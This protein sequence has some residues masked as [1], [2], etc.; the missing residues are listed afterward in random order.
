MI[1]IGWEA[2]CPR[3]NLDTVARTKIFSVRLE[4]NVDSPD[5]QSIMLV[6]LFT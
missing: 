3:T 5:F 4:F 1:P 2:G 6:T